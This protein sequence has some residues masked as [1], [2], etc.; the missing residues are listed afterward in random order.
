MEP[1][2]D[3]PTLEELP[4]ETA[5]LL[6]L[7]PPLNAFRM[8]ALVQNSFRGFL[9]LA[10]SV[11]SGADFDARLREIAVLR[12]VG[13]L[14]CTY[15]WSHHVTVGLMTGLTEKEIDIIKTGDPVTA[16]DEEG[17]L[18][19]RVADEITREARLGDETLLEIKNRYGNHGAA[20]L[21]LCCSY[22][23][24]L[25]RCLESMRVPLET[26]GDVDEQIK[27]IFESPAS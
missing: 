24:M 10:G 21:I 4:Q 17:N 18:L 19:C 27:T 11:L 22:F 2:I 15:A 14:N 13:V 16:L 7:L 6:K 1:I 23:N 25:A 20:A 3:L 9:D 8:M 5:D 26:G 12:V